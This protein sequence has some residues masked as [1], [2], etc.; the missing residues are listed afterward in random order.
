AQGDRNQPYSEDLAWHT[1]TNLDEELVSLNMLPDRS[2]RRGR[3]RRMKQCS[4]CSGESTKKRAAVLKPGRHGAVLG[5][6]EVKAVL[7]EDGEL[8]GQW[9]D[10]KKKLDKLVAS[11]EAMSIKSRVVYPAE[12]ANGV[13]DKFEASVSKDRGIGCSD[14]VE[15]NQ[16]GC[17][18][19]PVSDLSDDYMEQDLS[20]AAEVPLFPAPQ[21]PPS[22]DSIGIPE[23]DIDWALLDTMT[24][25]V[26]SSLFNSNGYADEPGWKDSEELRAE[27]DMREE[28]EIGMESDISTGVASPLQQEQFI[29][30]MLRLLPIKTVTVMNAVSAAWRG[31]CFAV[32]GVH[33]LTMQGALS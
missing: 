26:S 4:E 16:L 7:F 28:S 21:L 14:K 19:D 32:M 33:R 11:T 1:S 8:N 23:V 18:S 27:I 31:L 9:L 24:G 25:H 2:D 12:Q 29:P 15:V 6:S 10:R 5:G 3:K 30:D 13:I 22:S 20:S 17:D